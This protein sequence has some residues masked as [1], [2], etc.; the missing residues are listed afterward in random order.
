MFMKI[1]NAMVKRMVKEN[2]NVAISD[3]AAA[4]IARILEK[5]AKTIA[6]SAV[7]RAKK[8]GRKMVTS[9]DIDY[10]RMKLGE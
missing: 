5:K 4:A 3:S 7:G 8:Q 10:Y 6:K 9:E 1:S 2:S